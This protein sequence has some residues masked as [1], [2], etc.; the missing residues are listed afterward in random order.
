M[1]ALVLAIAIA[2]VT[3][4]HAQ[5]ASWEIRVPERIELAQGASGIVPITISVDRGFSVSKDG[6]VIIDVVPEPGVTI[7]KRR[8]GRPDAADPEADLPRFVIPVRADTAGDHTVKL[9]I[10]LWLCGG[11]VC[12]PLDVKRQT[13][14]AVAAAPAPADPPTP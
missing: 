1:R 4:A 12:R 2:A 6:P 5:P 3:P 14:V 7:K 13:T 8:L 9:R 10:R 11:K